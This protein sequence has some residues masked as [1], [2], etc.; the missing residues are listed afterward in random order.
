[1]ATRVWLGGASAV[2]KTQ[3]IDLV[4]GYSAGDTITLTISGVD[5][6]LTVGSTTLAD[7]IDD[8]QVMVNG[9]GTL[10]TGASV[11][12][13]GTDYG[14]W[15]GMSCGEFD[16]DTILLTGP[17][18]GYPFEDA[19]VATDSGGGT[20][21]V[22][23]GA[24]NTPT[25][26]GYFD[27]ADNWSG[28]TVPVDNDD[29]VFDH[30]AANSL[31][32]NLAQSAV[33]PLSLTITPGFRHQIGLPAVNTTTLSLPYPEYLA[34]FLQVGNSVDAN[35]FTLDIEST[36]SSMV[37]IDTGNDSV[38]LVVR[39]T[40]GRAEVGVP[41]FCWIGTGAT[42]A[43]TILA[44]DVGLAHEV[45]SSATINSLLCSPGSPSS[46]VVYA[47]SGLTL[48]T[49]DMDG[50]VVQLNGAATTVT[51]ESGVLTLNGSGAYT[52]LNVNGGT[53]YYKSSGTVTT[54][55]VNAGGVIDFRQDPRARTVTNTVLHAG[56]GYRD[57]YGSVA[58][59]GNGLDFYQCVPADLKYFE[60]KSHVTLT[61]SAV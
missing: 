7:I 5:L 52:T 24:T 61:L 34:T 46:T 6:I 9:S 47:G 56:A 37:K 3:K 26:P 18:D 27:N 36:G 22:P 54:L 59:G 41:S 17:D 45:G 38:T 49:F 16:S 8:L 4:T 21:T 57:P 20:I 58:V 28:A 42:N 1:M 13:Y 10:S 48:T 39:N 12:A 32:F 44:G 15:A 30:R 19:T 11:S 14:E 40:G 2:A 43:V 33:T 53:L 25:G 23:I 51:I 55:T 50:G 60:I 31:T 35:A 29:I